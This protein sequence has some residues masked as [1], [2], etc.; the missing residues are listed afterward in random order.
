MLM[1]CSTAC[2]FGG[3]PGQAVSTFS[4]VDEAVHFPGGQ[5]DFGDLTADVARDVRDLIVGTDQSFLRNLGNVDDVGDFHSVEVDR[6]DLVGFLNRGDEPAAVGRGGGAVGG[7]GQI[8]P[9]FHR[10]GGGVDDGEARG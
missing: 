6:G 10:V 3:G 2:L 5:A 4:G 9:V 7:G 1:R 8:D